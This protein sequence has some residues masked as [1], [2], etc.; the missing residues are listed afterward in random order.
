MAAVGAAVPTAEAVAEA[1]TAKLCNNRNNSAG[2]A[3]RIPG[4]FYASRVK[5]APCESNVGE[6]C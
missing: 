2:D 4:I 1:I 5:W 3:N 6:E